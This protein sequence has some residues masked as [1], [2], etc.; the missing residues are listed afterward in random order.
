[1][2]RGVRSKYL[3]LWKQFWLIMDFK[4]HRHPGRSKAMDAKEMP[5][6]ACGEKGAKVKS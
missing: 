4:G 5:W 1:M 2:K 6:M 3:E